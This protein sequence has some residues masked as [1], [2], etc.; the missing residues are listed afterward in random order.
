MYAVG[1]GWAKPGLP[2]MNAASRYGMGHAWF[3][4]DD[5][6]QAMKGRR[7]GCEGRSASHL[8]FEHGFHKTLLK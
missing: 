4:E 2:A 5:I 1:T 6:I 8:L 7:N 3:T